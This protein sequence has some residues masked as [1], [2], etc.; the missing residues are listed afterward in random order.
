[1]RGIVPEE[2]LRRTNKATAAMDAADGLREHR[3]DLKALWEDSRLERLGLVDGDALRRLAERPA[4]KQ[5]REAV[6]YSTISVEVWLRALERTPHD[7]PK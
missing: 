3:G 5:L 4:T 6:L 7:L 2:C 1:M